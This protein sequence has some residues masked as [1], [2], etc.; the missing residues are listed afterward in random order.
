MQTA[1]STGFWPRK[2]R[3]DRKNTHNVLSTRRISVFSVGP[4]SDV[5]PA[6]IWY[7]PSPMNQNDQQKAEIRQQVTHEQISRR[8]EELWRQYGSPAGRDDDIWLEAERQL[9]G[10]QN[11]L[12]ST[13]STPSSENVGGTQPA[14]PVGNES[15]SNPTP[16]KP[17]EMELMKRN[18]SG[19]SSSATTRSKSRGRSAGK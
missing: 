2:T 15:G 7:N 6:R 14:F 12:A 13:T 10:T 17:R 11:T 1:R 18:I 5:N 8:A 19:P 9:L 16:A 3:C 4:N